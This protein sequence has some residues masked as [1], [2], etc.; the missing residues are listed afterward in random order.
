MWKSKPIQHHLLLPPMT[1]KIGDGS[2]AHEQAVELTL[3]TK[4][5]MAVERM[6]PLPAQMLILYLVDV[7]L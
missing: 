2:H 3:P 1:Y 5:V 7:T 4:L 6:C